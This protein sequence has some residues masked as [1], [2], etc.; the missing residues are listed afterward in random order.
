MKTFSIS[1]PVGAWH[2]L[3]PTCLASLEAQGEGVR[4]SFLDASGD[5]RVEALADR[6]DHFFAYRRHGP[7]GG[8]SSAIVEGWSHAEGDIL[9]WLN[10]DDFLFPNAIAKARAVFESVPA[11]DVV[12]GNSAICD[13]QGRMTGYHWAVAPPGEN[14]RAGCVIS[15]PSCFF[16]REAY[17]SA[18][19]LNQDLHYTMD[20]DL[21]LRLLQ[22]GAK[23]QFLDEVLSVVYWG[24]GTKT[25]GLS[26][27]RRRELFRLIDT[28]TPP[29]LRFKAKRGFVLRA[30]LDEFRPA[31]IS[32]LAEERLRRKTPYVYGVG[33]RGILDANV[34]IIWAR[35][36]ADS[37]SRLQIEI[38]G[39]ASFDAP[40]V[41]PDAK[42]TRRNSSL[43]LDFVE[44]PPEGA[45]V[46]A[47]LRRREQG[48][49]RLL[50]CSW[51]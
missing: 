28:H 8:Q 25:L 13:E 39:D 51:L 34:R 46:E 17:E 12:S 7:D 50:K 18:G 1:V 37:S 21:W 27:L 36:S 24:Q 32:M 30:I 5:P 35:F 45:V 10:A 48:R 31:S 26:A 33:P 40:F 19:G 44:T 16:R 41:R 6:F 14:L 3:L 38:E 15:Q 20:W 2:D 4:V 11:V 42:V 9:G 23:F 43:I 49:A 47:H 29:R 22:G